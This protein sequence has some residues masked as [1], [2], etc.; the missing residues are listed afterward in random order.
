LPATITKGARAIAAAAASSPGRD[1]PQTRLSRNTRRKTSRIAHQA[2]GIAHANPGKF[3]FKDTAP[4]CVERGGGKAEPSPRIS[5][6]A[7]AVITNNGPSVA[8]PSTQSA[9]DHPRIPLGRNR[10][11]AN[12]STIG[13]ITRNDTGFT[14]NAAP[15]NIAAPTRAHQAPGSAKPR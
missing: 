12:Q 8:R 6:Y 7:R 13:T 5:Q 9:R 14:R 1:A 2:A 3:A 15:S 10:E 11:P 4:S